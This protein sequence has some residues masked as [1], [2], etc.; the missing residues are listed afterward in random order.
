MGDGDTGQLTDSSK[1]FH[2]WIRNYGHLPGYI[3]QK[4]QAIAAVRL[5]P[6]IDSPFKTPRCYC[7]QIKNLFTEKLNF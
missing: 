2:F 1:F 4:G 3:C 5:V 6:V 7:E